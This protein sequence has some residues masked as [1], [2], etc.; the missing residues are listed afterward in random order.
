M[1]CV[2]SKQSISYLANAVNYCTT[3]ILENVNDHIHTEQ[4]TP[5]M[6]DY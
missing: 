3:I 6:T 5:L 2:L 4:P 1:V